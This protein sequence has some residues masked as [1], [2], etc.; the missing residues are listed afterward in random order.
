MTTK[1]RYAKRKSGRNGWI[2]VSRSIFD[3]NLVGAGSEGKYSRL[4]AFLW[5]VSAAAFE[6]TTVL[7]GVE[8]QPGEFVA[9]LRYLAIK[10]GWT[11]GAVRHFLERLEQAHTLQH[12]KHTESAQ[13]TT[14]FYLCNWEKY[15]VPT[16]DEHTVDCTG[17][18]TESPQSK[19]ETINNTPNG[20]C[21]RTPDLDCLE[22]F[23]L[24]NALAHEIGLPQAATL[25]PGRRQ[26]LKARLK[27]H[28][29]LEGW[30]RALDNLK[31]S[32]FLCG[33]NDRGWRANLDFML[34]ASSFAKLI[35]GT[36]IKRGG[37][38]A[39]GSITTIHNTE[40]KFEDYRARMLREGKLK[41]SPN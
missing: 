26:T 12:R 38:R 4:E 2:A 34:Q 29:G 27:E 40:E 13:P 7:D 24:Y 5:I 15:Q 1:H 28:G 3:H 41:T 30:R 31:A 18:N 37:L 33:Q 17:S 8:L 11:P 36:H 16:E 32:P 35:D 14:V 39:L 23:T 6:R 9:S 19:Q 10:W 25:T 20:V 22:A 21:D